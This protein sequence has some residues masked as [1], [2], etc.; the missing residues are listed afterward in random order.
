MSVFCQAV[1]YLTVAVPAVAQSQA[2]ATTTIKPARSGDPRNARVQLLPTGDLIARAVPFVRLF[3]Y[4]YDVPV[5]GSPRLSPLP[6]WTVRERYD[7]EIKAPA[8][9]IPPNLQDSGVRTRIQQMIRELLADRF[10]LVMRVENKAMPIYA[11]TLASG[12]PKL[13]QSVLSDKEC[14]SNTDAEPCHNFVGGLGHPLDAKA[15]NMDD[16]ARYIENWTDLPVV[17]RTALN[18]LFTVNTEGWVPMRLPPPPPNAAPAAN[19]FA[20]LP[21]IF[22]VLG[23][24]GL[25]LNR[26]EEVLPVYTVEHIERPAGN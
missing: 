6:D 8:N 10:K 20:G 23:K 7:I 13:Q 17:N 4:A 15:I 19:P 24:L 5:N 18:G 21:T 26:Q 14:T 16:L 2:F 3:S 22:T 12:G 25:E 9:A 11:L 1:V